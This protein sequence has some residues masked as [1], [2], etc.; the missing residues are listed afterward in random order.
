MGQK[1]DF[2]S[3]DKRDWLDTADA[4]IEEIDFFSYKDVVFMLIGHKS[5]S[6]RGFEE[7]QVV[8]SRAFSEHCVVL[9][10][11]RRAHVG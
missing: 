7:N 4:G 10:D 6:R 3:V 2:F 8:P 9:V 11:G 5:F 1:N